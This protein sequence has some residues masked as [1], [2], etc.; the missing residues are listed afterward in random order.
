MKLY[1][2]LNKAKEHLYALKF[3]GCICR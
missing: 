2:G 1:R 3:W